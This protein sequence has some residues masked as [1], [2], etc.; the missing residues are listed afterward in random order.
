MHNKR[1]KDASS[2]F[3]LHAHNERERYIYIYL[4]PPK[5]MVSI[6]TIFGAHKFYV[7]IGIF[8]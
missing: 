8:Q 7:A 3:T 1:L 4:P 5:K 6:A 2:M